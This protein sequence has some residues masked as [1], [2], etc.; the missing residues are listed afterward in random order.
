MAN[1][2]LTAEHVDILW[3]CQ[4]PVH[5][6]QRIDVGLEERFGIERNHM[7][8]QNDTRLRQ[9]LL[10]NRCCRKRRG[11]INRMHTAHANDIGVKLRDDSVQRRSKTF[12]DDSNRVLGSFKRGSDVFEAERLDPK[13][14]P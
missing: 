3:E 2:L 8:P 13:E 9:N 12:V 10:C 4:F 6:A 7:P 14:W 1:R 5:R 11:D